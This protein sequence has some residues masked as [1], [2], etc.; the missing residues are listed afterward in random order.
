MAKIYTPR[1]IREKNR[2]LRSDGK[3][4]F[5]DRIHERPHELEPLVRKDAPTATDPTPIL[6]ACELMTS[7]RVRLV[8]IINAGREVEGVITGMDIID[9]LGGGPKHNIVIKRGLRLLYPIL[10][11]P[12]SEIMRKNAIIVDIDTKLPKLLE[13]MITYGV[14]AVPVVSKKGYE[15][16]ITEREVMKHLAGILVGVNVRDIMTDSVITI[17]E[18]KTLEDAMKLMIETGVR[19]LPVTYGREVSGIIAWRQII[20]LIGTHEIF[21]L[22]KSKTISEF[23]SLLVRDVMRK[24]VVT[25]SP[26]ADIGEAVTKMLERNVGSLLVT[27]GNELKGIVTEKDIIY[28][29]VAG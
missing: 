24:D 5:K 13:V 26:D 14:G 25:I 19:R 7:S 18:G 29:L 11:L 28:G 21:R 17:E 10:D 2:W 23:K 12:V 15:G 3:P 9:Y 1:R 16:I 20:D 27:E 4:N 8:P 6:K 22:I